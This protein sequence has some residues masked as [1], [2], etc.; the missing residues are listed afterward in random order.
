MATSTARSPP[1]SAWLPRNR[2]AILQVGSALA[3]RGIPLQ[4][5]YCAAKHAIQG[6]T[7][8]LRSE[9]IHDHSSVKLTMVQMPALNTPQFDWVKSRLPRKAAAGA[10]HL[11]ARSRG[12]SHRTMLPITTAASGTS[13]G[14]R[15]VAIV[16]NKIAPGL[17]DWYLGQQGYDA[18]Q[19]DGKRDPNR[20]NNIYAPVDDD[21]DHGA[22]GDFDDRA[23][24]HSF[25]VWADQGRDWILLAGRGGGILRSMHARSEE[26]VARRPG[27]PG[28]GNPGHGRT[29]G[30]GSPERFGRLVAAA[31]EERRSS[32]GERGASAP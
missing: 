7:D 8:S 17:G 12:R 5:A 14:L 1:S 13:A 15:C 25:Q 24:D 18:Q 10:A 26:G 23:S 31:F 19:Y 29:G 21:V 28:A 16:G 3:Y 32:S 22:H 9:L 20:P 4:S 2:G 27:R 11:P 30:A 6:F